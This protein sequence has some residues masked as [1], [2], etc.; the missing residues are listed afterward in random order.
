MASDR[1]VE[2]FEKTQGEKLLDLIKENF[3]FISENNIF[4][5]VIEYKEWPGYK[6]YHYG[7]KGSQKLHDSNC[8]NGNLAVVYYGDGSKDPIIVGGMKDGNTYVDRTWRG[9]SLGTAIILAAFEA[10]VKNARTFSFFSKHGFESRK[11]AHR[12]AIERAINEGINVPENVLKDYP[13][14][15]EKNMNSSLNYDV[16]ADA[17]APEML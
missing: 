7:K 16:D 12:L 10:G 5:K 17:V 13:D 15:Q 4:N 6:I 3:K 2:E 9:K 11:K 1:F 14:L 8:T